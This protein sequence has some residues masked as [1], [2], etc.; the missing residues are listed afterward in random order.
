MKLP[1]YL[2]HRDGRP[3][4][5][6]LQKLHETKKDIID[7]FGDR[8][9]PGQLIQDL[10]E[11]EQALNSLSNDNEWID[12]LNNLIEEI[13]DTCHLQY[14]AT[15]DGRIIAGRGHVVIVYELVAHRDLYIQIGWN[16]NDERTPA[17]FEK[18]LRTC[19]LARILNGV[20]EYNCEQNISDFVNTFDD[21]MSMARGHY[22][23]DQT[24]TCVENFVKGVTQ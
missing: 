19:H 15:V 20:A 21:Y 23:Y 7:R 10:A 17:D 9:V 24:K 12:R 16:P 22:V 4:E 14:V 6:E 3:I 18:P 8:Y 5:M 11:K 2:C 1:M 13:C